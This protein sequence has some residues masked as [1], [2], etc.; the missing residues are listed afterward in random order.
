V[1]CESHISAERKE[2]AD[3][4]EYCEKQQRRT[5]KLRSSAKNVDAYRSV[6]QPNEDGDSQDY[7]RNPVSPIE[8]LSIRKD[9]TFTSGITVQEALVAKLE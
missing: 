4:S 8:T 2:G 1:F 7:E 3:S 9:F 6:G 5:P